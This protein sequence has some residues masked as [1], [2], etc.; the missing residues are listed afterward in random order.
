MNLEKKQKKKKKLERPQ[1]LLHEDP[2]LEKTQES[3]KD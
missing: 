1:T 3:E 2:K